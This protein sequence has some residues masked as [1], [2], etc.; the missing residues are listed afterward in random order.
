M[1]ASSIIV[2]ISVCQYVVNSDT[3]HAAWLLT[4]ITFATFYDFLCVSCTELVLNVSLC[5]I[6]QHIDE[7]SHD[8]VMTQPQPT[9]VRQ[10]SFL[11]L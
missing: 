3:A 9:T 5:F 11:N 6:E 10:L 1:T 4:M 2:A 8:V 7:R